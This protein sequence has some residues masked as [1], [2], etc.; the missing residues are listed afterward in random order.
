MARR[1][2]HQEFENTHA[3]CVK[4]GANQMI[5]TLHVIIDPNIFCMFRAGDS[6]F[7]TTFAENSKILLRISR[8]GKPSEMPQIA[9]PRFL[10]PASEAPGPRCSWR[11][12]RRLCSAKTPPLR[13][14]RCA[15]Q[16]AAAFCLGRFSPGA[17]GRCGRSRGRRRTLW[18]AELYP[19]NRQTNDEC[20]GL[21]IFKTVQSKK[22]F[23]NN[24]KHTEKFQYIL[25]P[26]NHLQ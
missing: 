24:R 7:C 23:R 11:P 17:V 18:A 8:L 9:E 2:S 16:S 20:F 5:N 19:F 4:T 22:A 12:P 3:P 25:F 1:G 15:P 6:R 10:R 26:T 13:R 14:G 21:N